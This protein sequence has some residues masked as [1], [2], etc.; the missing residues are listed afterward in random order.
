MGSLV[1]GQVRAGADETLDRYRLNFISGLNIN[2]SIDEKESQ[3]SVL[4]VKFTSK[5][6]KEVSGKISIF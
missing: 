1:R 3:I 4:V 6:S 5:V 2:I